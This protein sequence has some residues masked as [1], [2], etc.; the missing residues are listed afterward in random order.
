MALSSKVP[1]MIYRLR[2]WDVVLK[3]AFVDKL[4]S[5]PKGEYSADDS[6]RLACFLICILMIP[7]S[8]DTSVSENS[9]RRRMSFTD[10]ITG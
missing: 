6:L 10:G 4:E 7:P 3:M 2:N 1:K 9:I 8:D 5:P